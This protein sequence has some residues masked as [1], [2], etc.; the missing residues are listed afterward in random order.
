MITLLVN[1]VRNQTWYASFLLKED[2]SPN[3]DIKYVIRR[4]YHG[5]SVRCTLGVK[6]ANGLPR[7]GWTNTPFANASKDRGLTHS[8]NRSQLTHS[9]ADEKLPVGSG[10]R[11]PHFIVSSV[12]SALHSNDCLSILRQCSVLRVR[13]RTFFALSQTRLW[14]KMEIP[15]W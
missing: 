11:T 12:M 14:M 3:L 9:C 1:S 13:F 10:V 15:V 4:W 7:S 8:I 6:I 5:F 2:Y